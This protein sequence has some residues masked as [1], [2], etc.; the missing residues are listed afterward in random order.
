MMVELLCKI[1]QIVMNNKL[2]VSNKIKYHK[3][4]NNNNFS[5]ILQIKFLKFN[6][7]FL[8]IMIILKNYNNKLKIYNKYNKNKINK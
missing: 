7:M 2:I 6:K 3:T 5:K 8:K 1:K 4:N